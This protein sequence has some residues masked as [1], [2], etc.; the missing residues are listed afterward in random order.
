MGIG[1]TNVIEDPRTNIIRVKLQGHI[2]IG[3][4]AMRFRIQV[5]STENASANAVI[6]KD[7]GSPTRPLTGKGILWLIELGA[8]SSFTKVIQ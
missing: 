6:Y 1:I 3:L 5:L 2:S 7:K 8:A 4:K